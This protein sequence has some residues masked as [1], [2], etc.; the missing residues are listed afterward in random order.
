MKMV[1]EFMILANQSVAERIYR[2][3]PQNALLR[4]HPQPSMLN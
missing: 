1:E 4:R 2:Y 3:F